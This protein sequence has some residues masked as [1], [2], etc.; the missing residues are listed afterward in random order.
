MNTF[1]AGQAVRELL[2]IS[3]SCLIR[4][5]RTTNY[6]TSRTQ[7]RP[8]IDLSRA[9]SEAG[10]CNGL[11]T[12]MAISTSRCLSLRMKTYLKFNPTNAFLELPSMSV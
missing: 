12:V 3:A 7:N 5:A 11:E 1:L 10:E 4:Q 6:K 8:C 9:S 2:I